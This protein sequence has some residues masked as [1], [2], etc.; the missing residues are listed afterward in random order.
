MAEKI[1]G[2]LLLVVATVSTLISVCVLE[3]DNNDY[4]KFFPIIEFVCT[5]L[6][7]ACLCID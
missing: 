7:I 6:G 4:V 3:E 1:F 5:A 2:V